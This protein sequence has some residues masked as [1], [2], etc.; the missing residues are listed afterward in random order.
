[1]SG[2]AYYTQREV[3]E[4]FRVSQGTVIKWRQL[5]F[6]EY[7]RPPG[8]TRILYPTEAVESFKKEFTYRREVV[9]TQRISGRNGRRAALE[10]EWR[11]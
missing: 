10:K 1:M 2:K 3:A 11:I 9:N 4:I 8:S 7:F 6:L 5:G